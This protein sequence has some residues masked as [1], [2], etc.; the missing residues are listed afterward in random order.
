MN[1]VIV[2]PTLSIAGAEKLAVNLANEYSKN[3]IVTLISIFPSSK[4]NLKND[5]MDNVNLVE[6][7]I[8]NNLIGKFKAISKLYFTLNNIEKID[9]L[10]THLTGLL[11]S[12]L[13]IL[14]E[15]IKVFH[16]IH[17]IAKNDA[18]KINITANRFLFKRKIVTP[19]SIS[20]KVKDSVDTLYGVN[21]LLIPNGSIQIKP[22]NKI[23]EVK[24]EILI[25]KNEINA[26]KVI[27]NIARITKQK[28]HKR[29]IQCAKDNPDILFIC[30][31]GI[32]ENEQGYVNVILDEIRNTANIYYIG[33][34][35]NISDYIISSDAVILTS[36]FEGL[37]IS[38]LESMSAGKPCISTPVGGMKDILDD[39][40][41]F[42]SE[43]KSSDALNYQILKWKNMTSHD[44]YDI[45]QNN[46]HRYKENFSMEK[47]ASLYLDCF[48]KD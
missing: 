20:N 2:I 1:I 48:K 35:N 47:C 29:L 46:I 39:S 8:K 5:I 40:I 36:D 24:N 37:P 41:G 31:G 43:N 32:S 4:S 19:I 17:N 34:V 26:T 14:T 15:K 25:L 33:V 10:H 42:L 30:L 3:H 27:C 28:N 16:T 18:N 7:N 44:I 11:Y 21:S 9:V 22:T 6:L 12:S 38:F 23:S 45:Y 13:Y